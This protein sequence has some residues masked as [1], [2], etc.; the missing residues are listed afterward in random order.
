MEEMENIAAGRSP[1]FEIMLQDIDIILDEGCDERRLEED[2]NAGFGHG[3]R[4]IPS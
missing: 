1:E 2:G 3:V 4:F